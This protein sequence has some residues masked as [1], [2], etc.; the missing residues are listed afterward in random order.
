MR[1]T[2]TTLRRII[3]E[4]LDAVMQEGP[5]DMLRNLG[6][7]KKTAAPAEPELTCAEVRQTYNKIAPETTYGTTGDNAEAMQLQLIKN[8]PGCFTDKEKKIA[9]RFPA[10]LVTG[11]GPMNEDE[12][13]SE[14]R[15]AA[16]APRNEYI[17]KK[18]KKGGKP[19]RVVAMRDGVLSI[20]FDDPELGVVRT[21][22]S[23]SDLEFLK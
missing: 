19:G 3:K 12:A 9:A 7:K 6:R 11:D 15:P 16:N 2:K 23:S 10:K 21:L 17:R 8:N 4:E 13:V 14:A 5:L 1:I 18:V 20:K 22:A